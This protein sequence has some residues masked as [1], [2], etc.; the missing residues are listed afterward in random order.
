[1]YQLHSLRSSSGNYDL[2]LGRAEWW[3]LAQRGRRSFGNLADSTVKFLARPSSTS[4]HQATSSATDRASIP[5]HDQHGL[6]TNPQWAD[7]EIALQSFLQHEY[8]LTEMLDALDAS[9]FDPMD[10]NWTL[11]NAW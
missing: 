3:P 4:Q 10:P 9:P 1:M 11:P 2:T 7:I 6:A 5:M 8:Q